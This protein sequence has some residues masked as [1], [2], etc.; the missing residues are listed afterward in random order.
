MQIPRTPAHAMLAPAPASAIPA[1]SFCR[2]SALTDSAVF[3]TPWLQDE[4]RSS[5]AAAAADAAVK[6]RQ[7]ALLRMLDGVVWLLQR[8]IL[9]IDPQ[10]R[11]N[12][13]QSVS[14]VCF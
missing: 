12:Y 4:V 3:S 8:H 10:V 13:V 2:I 6:S 9:E 5:R 1:R 11:Y 14:P 7:R